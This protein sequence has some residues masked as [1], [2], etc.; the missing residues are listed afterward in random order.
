MQLYFPNL[1]KS[2]LQE[3]EKADMLN[4]ASSIISKVRRNWDKTHTNINSRYCDSRLGTDWN[5]KFMNDIC[6][7]V[8]DGLFWIL[9]LIDDFLL[10]RDPYCSAQS[11]NL[12]HRHGDVLGFSLKL[13]LRLF[14]HLFCVYGYKKSINRSFCSTANNECNIN[15][16]FNL[17]FL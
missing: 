15:T 3:D 12:R 10:L 7:S 8:Y 4:Y 6:R 17:S 13:P 16:N 9:L 11:S 5:T 2:N 1:D 14:S